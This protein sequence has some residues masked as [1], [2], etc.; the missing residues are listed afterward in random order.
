MKNVTFM[1]PCIWLAILASAVLYA[2]PAGVLKINPKADVHPTAVLMGNIT[3]GSYTKIGPKVVIQGDVT[4]GHHV[5][6]LGN[7][8]ISADKLVISNYVRID[9]GAVVV[10]GRSV[11]PGIT[12]N[13]IPDRLYIQ[14]NCWIGMNATVRGSRM[15]DGSSVGNDA[16]A[17]FNTHL[18]K[19]A[20]LAHGAVSTYD[21]V[22]KE[23][24][25]AEGNPAKITKEPATDED[26]QRI[27]GLV[28][29]LWIHYENDNIAREIDRNPPKVQKS[30]PGIDGK[31][32]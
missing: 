29:S 19:G 22:I 4:I 10:D 18:E 3:I 5:N 2:Y 16:V 6:I 24:A 26:R 1:K 30:Y 27:F 31:Q 14:D 7:A 25:L 20:I 11:A 32:Y 15:E 21:M 23:N 8:V 28:P 9:Y 13:D 17:D 12:V